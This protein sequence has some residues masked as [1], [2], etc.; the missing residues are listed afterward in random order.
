V[1]A[2]IRRSGGQDADGAC[3]QLRARSVSAAR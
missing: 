1:L 3:G 2:T